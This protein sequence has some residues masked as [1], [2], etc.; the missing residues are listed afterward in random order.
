MAIDSLTSR[1]GAPYAI[2]Q[3]FFPSHKGAQ[4]L[5]ASC[6]GKENRWGKL[7]VT[8][9]PHKYISEQPMTNYDMSKSPGRTYKYYQGQPLFS[10]GYGLS[11]TAFQLQCTQK[12]LEGPTTSLA[13][14]CQVSNTGSLDGDE[15]IQVYHAALDIGK[16][17]H[18]LPKRALRDFQRV[19][20]PAGQVAKLSFNYP[21]STLEVVNKAKGS[22]YV[23]SAVTKAS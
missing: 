6:F 3:A 12:R 18:P 15:V 22:D 9:Y 21:L 10:F 4:A 11:L 7:P 1:S 14:D 20:V 16:V 5:G 13:F 8:M 2:V 19:R 17:D 23:K